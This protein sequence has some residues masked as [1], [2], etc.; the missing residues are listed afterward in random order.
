MM[1]GSGMSTHVIPAKIA[2]L[3]VLLCLFILCNIYIYLLTYLFVCLCKIMNGLPICGLLRNTVQISSAHVAS[4]V[5][6][7]MQYKS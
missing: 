3:N 2:S 7:L 5:T 6:P 1:T 4:Y